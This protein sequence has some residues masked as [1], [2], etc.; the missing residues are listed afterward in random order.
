MK[1]IVLTLL[2]IILVSLLAGCTAAADRWT[3]DTFLAFLDANNIHAGDIDA[4]TILVGGVDITTLTGIQVVWKG[5]LAGDP[6]LPVNG[7][8]YRNS[9]DGKTYIYYND[10]WHEMNEDGAAGAPGVP[11]LPGAAGADGA[12]GADGAAGSPGSVWYSG[13]GAPAVGLGINGDYY[14]NTSNGDVYAKAGGAW[15]LD[16]NI[17]GAQG[18]QGIQ[19]N[20]GAAGATGAS[21][22][23]EA[24]Y[25]FD[26][27]AS[28]DIG[29]YF[30]LESI[31]HNITEQIDTTAA[32]NTDGES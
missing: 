21:G 27:T 10:A 1:K 16:G 24:T 22:G 28:V 12:D 29:G 8:A 7:W 19:G 18:L 5:T 23:T 9:T 17:R 13:A 14:L 25:Y 20:P 31:P 32:K 26:D 30:T 11:G 15:G 6:A 2:A 4:D 3:D